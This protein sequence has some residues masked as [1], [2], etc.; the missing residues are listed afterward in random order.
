LKPSSTNDQNDYS[1]Y[2]EEAGKAGIDVAGTARDL[3]GAISKGIWGS[4]G[5]GRTSSSSS[6]GA[7][8]PPPGSHS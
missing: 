7:G 2:D 5:G 6:K 1:F 4:L 3:L 8:N